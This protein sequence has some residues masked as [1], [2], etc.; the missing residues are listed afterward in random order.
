MKADKKGRL[1]RHGYGQLYQENFTEIQGCGLHIKNQ[2]DYVG[3]WQD[4]LRNGS[5]KQKI[6]HAISKPGKNLYPT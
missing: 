6:V 4:D 5:G 2:R 3:F 1:I